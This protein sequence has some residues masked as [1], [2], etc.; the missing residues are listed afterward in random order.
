MNDKPANPLHIDEADLLAFIE[1]ELAQEREA[2]VLRTLAANPELARLAEGMRADR[3]AISILPQPQAPDGLLQAVD[4]TLEREMLLG[5]ADGRPAR[6]GLPVSTIQPVRRSPLKSLLLDARIQKLALAAAV[7]LIGAGATLQALK[8]INT[9]SPTPTPTQ[10][11][12]QD[13]PA[14]AQDRLA[15]KPAD[16]PE[17]ADPLP[18]T[19]ELALI[20]PEP[21]PE[22]EPGMSLDEALALAGEGRLMIRVR[23]ATP[24]QTRDEIDRLAQR[25]MQGSSWRMEAEITGTL[26]KAMHPLT[27][28]RTN[29]RPDKPRETAY[30]GNERSR[31]DL[32]ELPR[33]KIVNP[34]LTLPDAR[35]YIISTPLDAQILESILAQLAART[36]IDATFE[37]LEQPVIESPLPLDSASVFWWTRPPTFWTK[38]VTIP[39]LVEP[40]SARD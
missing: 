28:P 33:Q 24:L 11:F 26:A 1:D 23:T 34:H 6:D 32:P 8:L 15:A 14:P 3:E 16:K 35:A 20:G 30:A 29:S 10:N 7:L 40:A 9:P 13:E 38:N 5:L 2:A 12:A 27:M 37:A 21:L 31:R 18:Q 25:S 17:I 22:P 19:P 4:Q 36:D 39:V